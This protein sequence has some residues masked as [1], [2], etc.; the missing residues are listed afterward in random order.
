MKD[1]QYNGQKKKNKRTSKDLQNTTLRIEQHEPNKKTE[2]KSDASVPAPLV[3][4]VML[5]TTRT[6]HDI[7]IMLDANIHK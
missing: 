5:L 4:P 3:E 1:K 6:A 2:V 7:E